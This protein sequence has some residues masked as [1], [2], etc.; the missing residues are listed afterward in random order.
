M[1]N[2]ALIPDGVPLWLDPVEWIR[3][4]ALAIH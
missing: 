1:K 3:F 4:A 2:L